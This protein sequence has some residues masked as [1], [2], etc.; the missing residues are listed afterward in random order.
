[1]FDDDYIMWHE[2]HSHS[3]LNKMLC[4]CVISSQSE[5]EEEAYIGF[6]AALA[7]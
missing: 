5:T 7:T 2:F 6:Q 1:M 3:N 4:D